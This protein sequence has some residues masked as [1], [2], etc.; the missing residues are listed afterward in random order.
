VLLRAHPRAR[1]AEEERHGL[2]PGWLVRPF[3][4]SLKAPLLA[5]TARGRRA[6]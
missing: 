5:L 6:G 1:A 4:T 2:V 3:Y